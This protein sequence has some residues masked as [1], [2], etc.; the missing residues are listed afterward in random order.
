[1]ADDK[2]MIW[3]LNVGHGDCSYIELPNGARMMIDCGCGEDHW[4]SRLLK[5]YS[6]SGKANSVTIPEIGTKYGIDNLVI[7]HPHG[8]HMGDIESIHDDVGFYSLTGNY[9]SFIGQIP[10]ESIDFRKRGKMAAEKF[11]QVVNKYHGKY[12]AAR[13]RV[14]L[15]KPA[16]IVNN[17]RFIGYQDGIDLNELSWFVSLEIGG[18]KVLFT[19]DMTKAGVKKILGSDKATE[20]TNFVRGTTILK[21]PHHGRE[22]GCSAEMFEN[23]GHKPLLCVASDKVLDDQNEGTSNIEW[24]S[25]RTSDTPLNIDGSLQNRK[26]LT[27]RKDGDIL[28]TISTTGEIEIATNSLKQVR[29][30]VLS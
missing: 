22:N 8:D 5:H 20:F 17:K 3:F 18:H 12:V 28:I 11:R 13:D 30:I 24:Y 26:V 6:I 23:F 9:S 21:V 1:M 10:T 7:S 4:P 19:G 15:C 27:T 16:C 25:A 14:A 2:L 29:D